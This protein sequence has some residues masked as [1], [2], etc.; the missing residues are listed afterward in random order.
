LPEKKEE[1][2]SEGGREK[3]TGNEK[4]KEKDRSCVLIFGSFKFVP[5]F[6][7]REA[8]EFCRK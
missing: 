5:S 6:K 1:R 4:Q 8:F 2:V 3:E 7:P